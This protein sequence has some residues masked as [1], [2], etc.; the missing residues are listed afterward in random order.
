M[1]K[2]NWRLTIAHAF[3]TTLGKGSFRSIACRSIASDRP[4]TSVTEYPLLDSRTTRLAY[5]FL[6]TEGKITR[7]VFDNG[8]FYLEGA[9][10]CSIDSKDG[11]FKKLNCSSPA[12]F[13]VADTGYLPSMSE[14]SA[15]YGKLNFRCRKSRMG[16]SATID[17]SVSLK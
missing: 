15:E 3:E 11:Q 6:L 12:F 4:V 9:T 10:S 5:Q 17:C 13:A 8:D 7:P 2:F 14:H 16:T 1:A